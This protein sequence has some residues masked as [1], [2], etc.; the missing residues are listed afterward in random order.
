MFAFA[1]MAGVVRIVPSIGHV[2]RQIVP[3]TAF[4]S[5]VHVCVLKAFRE[6]GV[7]CVFLWPHQLRRNG[8]RAIAP[9]IALAMERACG[10]SMDWLDARARL[11]GMEL[12]VP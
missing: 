5:L 8:L 12:L 1:R 6:L 2:C 3:V 4:A 10:T 7:F 9:C 11:V